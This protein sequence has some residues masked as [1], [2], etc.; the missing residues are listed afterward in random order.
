MGFWRN[1]SGNTALIFA[2]GII[3]LFVAVGAAVDTGRVIRAKTLLQGATDSAALAASASSQMTDAELL[4]LANDYLAANGAD[5]SLTSIKSVLTTAD[6]M[7]GTFTVTMS[8]YVNTSLMAIVGVDTMAVTATTEVS[9]GSQAMEVALV[10]DN[11]G[12]MGGQK[13]ADLIT[14]ATLLVDE[15]SNGSNGYSTLKFGIV[16]FA[17]YVNVGPGNRTATWLD[18][19]PQA[20]GNPWLGCVGSRNSPLDKTIVGIDHYPGISTSNDAC[21]EPIS[22]L[23]SNLSQIRAGIKKMN[24]G[25]YTY[26]PG[27]LLWGWNIIDETEPFTEAMSATQRRS[28]GGHRALVLMTDGEN[29]VFPTYPDQVIIDKDPKSPNYDPL[30]EDHTAYSDQRTADLCTAIKADGIE[31]FTVAFQVS[32]PNTIK[33][34]DDCATSPAMSFDAQNGAALKAAFKEIATQLSTMHLSK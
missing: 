2:L 23:T 8:G 20:G 33:M 15:L 34:L 25:G 6:R 22:P 3:P 29:T 16:P 5:R 13:I 14:S 18:V 1:T 27:G 9:A 19:P 32:A 12:S 31:L 11:T 30:W 26:I 4:A 17:Q 10:L 28:V 7:N 21:P 24:A